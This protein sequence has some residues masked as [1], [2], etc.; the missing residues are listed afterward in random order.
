LMGIIPGI[1]TAQP[2]ISFKVHP[3]GTFSITGN[4]V[5]LHDCYPAIN[6]QSL[7]PLSL[8]ISESKDQSSIIYELQKGTIELMLKNPGGE[9][10][11][12]TVIRG[13][14]INPS[15][16]SPIAR[17]EVEG[18]ERFYRS[19]WAIADNAG[20]ENWPVEK[21]KEI[22]NSLTG[23]IPAE[24]KTLV[25]S[26]RDYRR[27]FSYADIYPE[28]LFN[29]KKT[30]DITI[31]TE[32][33]DVSSL[34]A[35]FITEGSTPFMA[36]NE[37]AKQIARVMGARTQ[38]PQTYHW[39]SWYYAYYYLTEKKLFDYL[40]GFETLEPRVPVKT[41]QI[42]VGYFPH[43][44]DWLEPGCNF[45]NG[46]KESVK[47]IK[48]HNYRAGIWIAPYMVG[49][50]SKLYREHP[51]WILRN[52]DGS[53][54]H[55]NKFYDE[56]RLWGAFDEEYYLLDT[57]NPAVM[58]YL[59]NVFR[60]FR[61]MGITFFKTDFMF[62]GAKP[63]HQ[64]DRH[65]PGKTSAEYQ[66]ELYQLIREEIGDESFWLGCISNYAPM[67]GF[68]D[69]MRISWDIGANWSYAQSF[70]REVQGQQFFNNV[71]WQNDPDAIILRT[72]YNH[73]K[74]HE[75]E[76][77][78]LYMG[79]LGGAVNTSDLFHEIPEKF[80]DIFRYLQPG[81]EKNTASF[82]FLGQDRKTDVLVRPM[83]PGNGR[84]VLFVN[85]EN[86]SVTEK[87]KISELTGQDRAT[88]YYWNT[89]GSIRIGELQELLI[90]LDPHHSKL[91]YIS[92]EG[93][94]PDDIN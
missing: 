15:T 50:R 13:L 83:R 36:M 51:E 73:M 52:K 45:P 11:I 47:K 17:A 87:F 41:I 48:D 20:I 78:A 32:K 28:G 57:S 37:E 54:A 38:T 35:V 62:W 3:N 31:L 53:I 12:E 49:N 2:G 65:T 79:M 88:C 60:T 40:D 21:K 66:R 71:W 84:A 34:P 76:T 69:A 1:L 68:V 59:R 14:E 44:G 64:V 30:I 93:K 39:C 33:V 6:G 86:T 5:S 94:A 90:E 29:D 8:K 25:I 82:P 24:G 10:S 56:N 42:D 80:L 70:F 19:P 4:A 63:S 23:L 22:S 55:V 85:R 67:I 74:E 46:I 81:E 27:F 58:E 75:V 43:V 18:A 72:E 92:P 91:I 77:L 9:I 26:T 89:G 61:E 7:K 16:F